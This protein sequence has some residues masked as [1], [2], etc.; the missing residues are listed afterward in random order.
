MGGSPGGCVSGESRLLDVGTGVGGI[1]PPGTGF[2]TPSGMDISRK[3]AKRTKMIR[4]GLIGT[5]GLVLITVVTVGVSRLEP[6][7]PGVDRRTLWLDTVKR[8]PMLREVRGVRALVSEDVLWIPSA[9]QGRVTRILVEPGRIV[10]PNT[11]RLGLNNPELELELLDARSQW[12]SAESRLTAW[13]AELEDPLLAMEADLTQLEA[14]YEESELRAEVDQ[15]H[16]ESDLISDLQLTLSKTRVTQSQQL[17]KV[18]RKRLDVYRTRT[19]PAQLAEAKAAVEHAESRYS[20]RCSEIESLKVKA[21]THGVRAQVK[22]RIE[23]GQ[24]VTPGTIL[25]KITNPKKRKA[26]LRIPE[27]QARDVRIGLPAEVDRHH[28]TVV[29]EVSRIDP[30]VVEGNVTVCVSLED[31]LPQGARPDPSVVGTIEIERLEDILYVGRPAYATTKGSRSCS[32]SSRTAGSPC[33]PAS[34]SAEA[35]SARS[36]SWKVWREEAKS[37]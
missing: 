15:K 29:G 25:A 34:S 31:A 14:A 37:F 17:L 8:G 5:A 35:P 13:M 3:S 23:P 19:M 33:G 2:A 20:L 26:Q 11:T 24:S 4:R 10:E 12:N 22:E 6:T 27:A 1:A 16:Y 18:R 30:T 7:V 21:G 9:V 28:G 32:R 36:K